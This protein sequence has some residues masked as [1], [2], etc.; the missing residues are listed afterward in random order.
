MTPAA[1]QDKEL[2]LLKEKDDI[3]A[4]LAS[5]DDEIAWKKTAAAQLEKTLAALQRG[6]DGVNMPRSAAELRRGTEAPPA[7]VEPP[8]DQSEELLQRLTTALA[9]LSKPWESTWDKESFDRQYC[10]DDGE[11]GD[12]LK[13]LTIEQQLV[14]ELQNPSDVSPR[15]DRRLLGDLKKAGKKAEVEILTAAVGPPS[16]PERQYRALLWLHHHRELNV[17]HVEPGAASQSLLTLACRHGHCD[18]AAALLERKAEVHHQSNSQLTALAAACQ[19]GSVQCARLLLQAA[20]NCNEASKGCSVLALASACSGEQG[21]ALTKLLL[22][23]RADVNQADPRGRT[24]LMAAAIAG[25]SRCC[26][27]LLKAGAC[28]TDEDNEA[29][30]KGG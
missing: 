1:L 2:Q 14:W 17:S 29:G 22:E 23:F 28:A 27:A 30:G 26:E 16:D 5:W 21:E 18:V 11:L 9:D 8:K 10:P 4:Q 3:L 25:N 24:P 12:F 13:G 20:A 6:E 15:V 7:D 19:G